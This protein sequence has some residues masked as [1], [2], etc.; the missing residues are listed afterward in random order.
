MRRQSDNEARHGLAR[1]WAGWPVP[2]RASDRRDPAHLRESSRVL[3]SQPEG[4]LP[5]CSLMVISD[6]RRQ[7]L[8]ISRLGQPLIDFPP[9]TAS[10]RQAGKP[11]ETLVKSL[12]QSSLLRL[13][14]VAV[15]RKV[16]RSAGF[17]P[18]LAAIT[19]Q[20]GCLRYAVVE[21]DGCRDTRFWL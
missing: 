11:L 21:D 12:D 2:V 20:A 19:M 16:V 9:P 10:A 5:P 13:T 18:A 15:Q 7:G 6:G 3:V 1:W 4:H 14:P 8:K 17:Q